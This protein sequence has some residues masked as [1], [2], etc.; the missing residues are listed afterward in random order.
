MNMSNEP[1]EHRMELERPSQK[2]Y[3][4]AVVNTYSIPQ[5]RPETED[6]VELNV[7]MAALWERK[8]IIAGMAI[9]GLLVGLGVSLLTTPTYRARA[10]LQ[11]E[12]FN[13][14]QFLREVAP[15]SP[16]LPNASPENYLQNAVKLLESE[17]LAKR[18]A[19]KLGIHDGVQQEAWSQSMSQFGD[20]FHLLQPPAMTAEERR[21]QS[22]QKALNLRTSL[23][24]QVIELFY[25]DRDPD[26]AAKGANTAASEF[27]NLNREARF[28]LAQDTTDWL[29]KQAGSLK[30]T[31]E[32]SNQQ[33]LAF[34]RST[35]LVFAGKQ[36]TLAED[37]M[38]QV[39][40]ALAKAEADRATKQARYETAKAN[41]DVLVSDA[42]SSGP[43]RQYQTDLENLRRELAQL[44]T[45]Y[46]PTNYKV[47]RVRAQ[48]AEAEK[49]IAE[50]R[51]DA[52]DRLRTDFVSAASLEQLLSR[53]EAVQLKL[54]QQQMEKERQ[55]DVKKS[56]IDATQR[57][58][59]SMLEKMKEAGAA[60]AFR[61]TNV[62]I[63]DPASV[64]S[65]PYSPKPPLN[66]AIGFAIGIV[67]GVGLTL[68]RAG[69]DNKVKRPGELS[70]LEVPELG[71]IP[72]AHIARALDPRESR[73]ALLR[74]RLGELAIEGRHPDT[75]L[76]GESF[77]AVLTSILFS[78]SFRGGFRGNQESGRVLVVT[79]LDVK[80]GK[81]T[82]VAN[83]ART[84]AERNR[85]VLVIDADLRRPRLHEWLGLPNTWGLTDMLHRGDFADLSRSP[86][87]ALV[88]PTRIPN[89]WILPSGAVE[90][91]APR[92]LHSCSADLGALLRRFRREFDMVLIDTPP[93]TLYAD[94]RLLG[95]MSDGLLVVV[96]A[97]TRSREELRSA[98]LQFAQDQIPVLGTILNDW[99]MVSSRIR[100]YKRYQGHYGDQTA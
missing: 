5:A 96:R 11:L 77:R 31:L 78:D 26:R 98:Y 94:G 59:E 43:L 64:P 2:L 35:G 80:E 19:A 1:V 83:L 89:L 23:Q 88:R 100:A 55:Y 38:R 3:A 71:V 7:L 52:L 66:M 60:S 14:D 47:Q 24:S 8:A 87:E 63:I 50:E 93:M 25:D 69:S 28:Q 70:R 33:L 65:V 81:T 97:N 45:M 40:D 86:L 32:N 29:N 57:L 49:S 46:T 22:V 76:W 62:R 12:G 48:I 27:V 42:L 37:R 74:G 10:S 75:S 30:A 16:S 21:I 53:T 56:E 15:I 72:S 54:V 84:A 73:R 34:A 13:N 44:Q 4:P 91:N 41:P 61:S 82:V 17:T 20:W 95:R 39:Q 18:V 92:L 79:S 36:G 58:Y 68:L 99:K 51:H 9:L 67:G 6:P 85:R 90:A